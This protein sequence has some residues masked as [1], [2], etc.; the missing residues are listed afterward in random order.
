MKMRIDENI[1][2]EFPLGFF[3][4]A[5][6]RSVD[7]RNEPCPKLRSSYLQDNTCIALPRGP[8]FAFILIIL[9]VYLT[10]K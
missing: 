7:S 1:K 6:R 9:N 3:G 5:P 8:H 10:R 4:I 2:G